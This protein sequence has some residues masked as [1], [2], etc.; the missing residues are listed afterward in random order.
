MMPF[1]WTRDLLMTTAFRQHG[2]QGDGLLDRT[3][4]WQCVFAYSEET[5]LTAHALTLRMLRQQLPF[6][7][8]NGGA[9]ASENPL[10]A[11]SVRAPLPTRTSTGSCGCRN[12]VRAGS[13]ESA[14]LQ[15]GSEPPKTRVVI[16]NLHKLFYIMYAAATRCGR[17]K[18]LADVRPG[19]GN[20]GSGRLASRTAR[21][22]IPASRRSAG[23]AIASMV[24]APVKKEQK[25]VFFSRFGHA[26]CKEKTFA[27]FLRQ[28]A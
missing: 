13:G 23:M 1:G 21:R 4:Q 7:L 8:R 5:Q 20:P 11:G 2:R 27:N 14:P 18:R 16:C 19:A 17:W 25:T 9:G 12:Q 22:I 6:Q 3:L 10:R 28:S 24:P 15:G 26:L